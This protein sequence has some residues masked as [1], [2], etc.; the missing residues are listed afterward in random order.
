M[1]SIKDLFELILIFLCDKEICQVLISTILR[2]SLWL[3]LWKCNGNGCDF[4]SKYL[5]SSVFLVSDMDFVD[6]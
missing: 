5:C 3:S 1:L 2:G 4:M 6:V